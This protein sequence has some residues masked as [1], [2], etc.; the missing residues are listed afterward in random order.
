MT[1]YCFALCV[2]LMPS[3]CLADV[4]IPRSTVT[5]FVSVREYP[6][7]NSTRLVQLRPGE[8]LPYLDSVPS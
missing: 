8:S 4:V 1:K 7:S 5:S 6:N 2:V 3:Y